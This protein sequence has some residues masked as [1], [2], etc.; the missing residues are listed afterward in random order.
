MSK[1]GKGGGN[2]AR[3]QI[4]AGRP[5]AGMT[6]R[7][8]AEHDDAD[9]RL[10]FDLVADPTA[11]QEALEHHELPADDGITPVPKP[12]REA[13][14]K[15][16]LSAL[17][18]LNKQ[19]E[20]YQRCVEVAQAKAEKH[21][22]LTA[23]LEEQLASARA[24]RE[25][26][27]IE[28]STAASAGEALRAREAELAAGEARLKVREQQAEQAFKLLETEAHERLT[29]D[30]ARR[31]Q[32]HREE[33]DRE[34]KSLEELREQLKSDEG[35][36]R[37]REI[38]L[39]RLE[40]R[41]ETEIAARAADKVTRLDGELHLAEMQLSAAE[42]VI[43][44]LR[45]KLHRLEVERLKFGGIDPERLAS[46]LEQLR[47]ENE[48]LRD[49]LAARLDDDSLDRLRRLE[50]ENHELRS[51]REQLE[52]QLQEM[53]N[54]A[55]ANKINNLQVQ[56]LKDA[57]HHFEVV[58][59]G[60]Q[61]RI[62]ELQG[63]IAVLYQ[64]REDPNSPLFPKCVDMD[65]DPWLSQADPVRDDQ[66][67]L[68][69]LAKSLQATMLARRDLSFRFNDIC[70]TLGGMAMSRLHLLEGMS[71]I[72]KTS[73]PI[74]L[75]EALGTHCAVIEVQAGWRDRTD[76]FG[77][78]N[79][80]DKRY[81]ESEFLQALYM[82]Q[83]KRYQNLPFFIVL[84]EMNLSRPEQYFSVVLSKLENEDREPIQ[85][86]TSGSGRP[87]SLMSGGTSIDLPHNVWF[88]GTANQ[89]ESTLE[90]ADKT[91]NRAHLM[92]LPAK[93]PV[94]ARS[95]AK[96]TAYSYRALCNA[97]GTARSRYRAERDSAL[98]FTRSLE[99]D[100]YEAGRVRM[101]PRVE[102]QLKDFVP[103][104]V[105]ARKGEGSDEDGGDYDDETQN[106]LAL[107]VDHFV[108][109]KLLRRLRDRYDAKVERIESLRDTVSAR[110]SE[111][112]DLVGDPVR[113]LRVLDDELRR[114]N[115]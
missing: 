53:H 68:S 102:A 6:K 66:P 103:V 58:T 34:R 8:A 109:T 64:Q 15:D 65:D 89:D 63:D 76:L 16:L 40:V 114:L 3:R 21:D 84:D 19:R 50:D 85:L 106:G 91:Y 94:L 26:A 115:G 88:V 35:V 107:A 32:S 71:G 43:D 72:G 13:T 86:V 61:T 77:H 42:Q 44:D 47:D 54:A 99:N 83:T 97:F 56:Q 70:T 31:R 18:Q 10:A 93:H 45:A 17:D 2:R 95:S 104:V 52:Y 60:Y 14:Q 4:P 1:G 36:L 90:F 69:D 101:S 39:E 75:A 59:R 28:R 22:R 7:Q 82:A 73:L 29:E 30:L 79:T 20:A 37:R 110:W 9:V 51:K 38:N 96:E 74:A 25:A 11:V 80:F 55:V 12:E 105:A 46:Q 23:G 81:E 48:D 100:L 57:E 87:P 24:D 113:C 78:H 112:P 5:V 33:L 67:N 98:A 49:K 108:A 62:K 92:E 27:A 111:H 41:A